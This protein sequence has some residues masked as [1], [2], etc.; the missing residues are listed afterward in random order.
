MKSDRDMQSRTRQEAS[1][2]D[3]RIEEEPE[4]KRL[5][6]AYASVADV[7]RATRVPP[8][9][10]DRSVLEIGCFRGDEAESLSGFSGSYSG[11]DISPAAIAHCRGLKLAPNFRFTVDDAN[12]MSTIPDHSVDYA[13]GN[14][15]LH[16]LDLEL[17]ASSFARK[18]SPGG[19]GRFI[20]PARGNLLL[21]AFRK[22]TPKLRTPDEKPFDT[23]AFQILSSYLTVEVSH[24]ALLRPFIPMLCL[25]SRAAT[26]LSRWADARLLR[27]SMFQNQAWLL[28]ITL[29][30]KDASLASA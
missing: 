28:C 16:H 15:V 9:C 10:L 11:I 21:R 30:A 2:H 23:A 19:F 29:S 3:A 22:V 17:F 7:Y 26:N 18:L 1:F 8:E 14:G 27:H 25:N 4:G 13:F 24:H 5:G 12:S 6:Y 20:E